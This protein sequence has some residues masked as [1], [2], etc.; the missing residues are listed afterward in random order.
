MKQNDA[1]IGSAPEEL[2]HKLRNRQKELERIVT[3]DDCIMRGILRVLGEERAD[4]NHCTSCQRR[5]AK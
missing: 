4:C 5:K 3:G 1:L 2:R